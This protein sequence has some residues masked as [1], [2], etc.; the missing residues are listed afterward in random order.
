[1]N[2]HQAGG[3]VSI[4][5]SL[6]VAPIRGPLRTL[7]RGYIKQVLEPKH[8]NTEFARDWRSDNAPRVKRQARHLHKAERLRLPSLY[9]VLYLQAVHDGQVH[10]LGLAS[11]RV[12]TNNGVGYIVDA[13]QNLVELENM[14]YHGIGTGGTAEAAS[15]AALVAE[16]TTGLNP[17]N[18][19]ATGTT[20]EAA[21][22]IYQTVATNNV[23]AT[24]ALTEHGIFSQAATGGGVLLDR[25]LYSA[26]NL[27]S[28]DSIQTDYRLTV[29]AG[30]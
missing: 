18:T 13:F 1:M 24:V 4:G 21:S 11:L 5:G 17:D 10:D 3:E 30:S 15:D 9:G 7:E 26:V 23:D 8:G 29:V 19:R 16:V 20:T 12:V 27:V 28:G 25:S 22:N 2:E 14:K 6:L